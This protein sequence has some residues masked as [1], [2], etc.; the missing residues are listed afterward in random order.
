M[1]KGEKENKA[2]KKKSVEE[3]SKKNTNR[4]L[5]ILVGILGILIG[6]IIIGAIA[7]FKFSEANKNINISSADNSLEAFDKF[8]RKSVIDVIEA[9]DVEEFDKENPLEIFDFETLQED[10]SSNTNATEYLTVNQPEEGDMIHQAID[11]EYVAITGFR[12]VE[13]SVNADVYEVSQGQNS[14]LSVS[15]YQDLTGYLSLAQS[16]TLDPE[17]FNNIETEIDGSLLVTSDTEKLSFD[18]NIIIV[19]EKMYATLSNVEY[20]E[21]MLDILG[22]SDSG[23]DSI[24]EGTVNM[25]IVEVFESLEEYNSNSTPIP[26]NLD[27]EE[28]D[29]ILNSYVDQVF[30]TMDADD[31]EQFRVVLSSLQ[32]EISEF[33]T[34]TEFIVNI[35]EVDP[36][37]E[38]SG[39]ECFEGDLNTEDIL[40]NGIEMVG[41]VLAEL[42][43]DPAFADQKTDIER[44][45]R[46]LELQ[47]D[48][49]KSA[50][51]IAGL[52]IKFRSC[53]STTDNSFTGLGMQFSTELSGFQ[54]GGASYDFDI[55]NINSDSDK[56]IEAPEDEG[57][58]ITDAVIDYFA[59]SRLSNARFDLDDQDVL[60]E[61]VEDVASV[62]SNAGTPTIYYITS[63]ATIK[64][65]YGTDAEIGYGDIIVEYDNYVILYNQDSDEI[66]YEGKL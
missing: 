60:V 63:P 12:D 2:T 45:L 29:E 44:S 19:E 51:D 64:E 36:I 4:S 58:D 61:L 57:T 14:S 27:P 54:A 10:F 66:L 48:T 33:V 16:Q 30:S 6:T 32:S 56:E 13:V 11:L 5:A 43:D 9:V 25:D 23:I 46:Q 38:N 26:Q 15:D 47:K 42:A 39:S 18:F 62:P 53:N 37:R 17:L 50:A 52:T 49:A 20:D 31:E 65:F 7:Y 55:L 3:I 24:E 8:T 1:E 21:N 40:E 28:V 35:E 34:D 41:N 22:L 59:Q